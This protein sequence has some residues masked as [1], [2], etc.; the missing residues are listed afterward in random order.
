MTQAAPT[1]PRV[2]WY[3][4]GIE[5]FLWGVRA[6][7]LLCHHSQELVEVNGTIA[8]LVDL[9]PQPTPDRSSEPCVPCL[10][11]AAQRVPR[12]SYPESL[13]LLGLVPVTA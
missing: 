5:Q 7:Q 11:Q 2:W 8:I 12:Q 10:L 6:F 3:L 1:Q 4:E 13:A 9:S